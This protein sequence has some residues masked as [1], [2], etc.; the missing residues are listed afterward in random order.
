MECMCYLQAPKFQHGFIYPRLHHY[1]R[2]VIKGK[3]ELITADDFNVTC[4]GIWVIQGLLL[5][6]S[7]LDMNT[8]DSTAWSTQVSEY[9][10]ELST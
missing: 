3:H 2:R 8:L 6:G 10:R 9:S 4:K 1:D 5:L 7:T